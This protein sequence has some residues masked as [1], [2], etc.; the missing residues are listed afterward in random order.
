MYLHF[1]DENNF[2]SFETL[3]E[4]IYL[5]NGMTRTSLNE[6]SDAEQQALGLYFYE[7]QTPVYDPK[8]YQLTGEIIYNHTDRTFVRVVEQIPLETL[9][10]QKLAEL[11]SQLQVEASEGLVCSNGIKLQVEEEDLVRWTQLSVSLLAFQPQQCLVRDYNNVIHAIS[12]Q[13]AQ[14]MM[15]E[16]AAWAQA[17]LA[18]VWQVK[19][20]VRNATTLDELNAVTLM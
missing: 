7:D 3:P 14:T 4:R 12:L 20:G 10:E 11:L 17:H 13:E 8:Y 1:K 15:A 2:E 9:K 5:P 18:K 6:L 19:D 16:V